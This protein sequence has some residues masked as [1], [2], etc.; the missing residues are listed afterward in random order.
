MTASA[1]AHSWNSWNGVVYVATL[2]GLQ[3][4]TYTYQCTADG[5]TFSAIYN[6]TVHDWALPSDGSW[7]WG[8]TADV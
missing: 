1:Q 2:T 4:A 5:S 6:F 7:T 8:F 3:P